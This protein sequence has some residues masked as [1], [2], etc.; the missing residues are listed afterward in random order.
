MSV[1]AS[2]LADFLASTLS[3]YP[4]NTFNVA[5][6]NNVYEACRVYQEERYVVDGGTDIKRKVQLS[7]SG[8]AK[9]RRYYDVDNPTVADTMKTITVPWT[10]LSTDYSW[11]DL[12]L[13]QNIKSSVKGYLRL[14]T[15]KRV[16]ALHDLANLIEER[17]W[18]T[19]TNS[20]DELYPYGVPYY[21]NMLN[22]D[23]TAAGFSGKTIRFQD[24][25]T[26]TTC[27]GIDADAEEKW[28]N[29]A[30]TYSAIDNELLKKLRFAFIE[31]S[32]K[33]PLFVTDPD[34]VRKS[35]KRF[36]TDHANVASLQDLADAKDD[37]HSGKD[38]L[39]NIMMDSGGLVFIN[40]YPVVP[41]KQLNDATDIVTSDTTS[42]IYF[43]DFEQFIP[44]V[45]DGYWMEE[46][47]P[48]WSRD[49]HTTFTIY[50]DGAHNNLCKNRRGVGFVGHLAITS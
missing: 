15:E 41:I 9:Y 11:D 29:Y 19:P 17:F 37:N 4:K 6:D 3:D 22:A 46:K 12:E 2:E 26:S 47:E 31:T 34:E 16:D 28:R 25:T 21:I 33:A 36:Y 18:K 27:A 43:V 35:P 30:F 14:M 50:I 49:Q 45:H 42:P 44:V 8:A 39:G 20:S 23:V 32:F 48:M 38:V 10:R 24:G 40:R 7:T 1:K 13:L 5:W